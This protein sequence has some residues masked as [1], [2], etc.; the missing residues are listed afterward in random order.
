MCKN[1]TQEICPPSWAFYGCLALL[2]S[3]P[4]GVWGPMYPTTSILPTTTSSTTSG[5]SFTGSETLIYWFP[6][7]IQLLSQKKEI[8]ISLTIPRKEEKKNLNNKPVADLVAT[9]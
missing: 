3:L 4:A 6:P 1:S 8:N 7:Y 2:V 9:L 5:T